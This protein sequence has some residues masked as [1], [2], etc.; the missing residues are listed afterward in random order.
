MIITF[1]DQE[2]S[3]I[4]LLALIRHHSAG[5]A[6]P[7]KYSK[8]D[9]LGI[10][11]LGAMGEA[12]LSKHFN[13]AVSTMLF[14]N[15]DDGRD[16]KTDSGTLQVKTRENPTAS[17]YIQ[18]TRQFRADYGVLCRLAAPNAIDIVAFFTK[19]AWKRHSEARDFN[20]SIKYVMSKDYM[21]PAV[22]DIVDGVDG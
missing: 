6:V 14:T 22:N 8:L 1:T 19:D 20:G 4:E 2:M 5:I 18:S 3:Q 12:A 15:R 7:P 9:A 13:W 17:L 11:R 16:F 10:D 21:N